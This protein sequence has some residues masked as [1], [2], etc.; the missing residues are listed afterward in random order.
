[1]KL[2]DA[3]WP[4][5]RELD[6][7]CRLLWGVG[8]LDLDDADRVRL[9]QLLAAEKVRLQAALDQAEAALRT[10]RGENPDDDLRGRLD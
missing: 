4:T 5:L 9:P 3:I 8:L 1:M 2:D 10:A 7:N 6:G